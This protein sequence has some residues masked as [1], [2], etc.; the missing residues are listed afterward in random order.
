MREIRF[1]IWNKNGKRML[2]DSGLPI[3]G[4]KVIEE[5]GF[6]VMQFTGLQDK[7]GQKIYEGDIVYDETIKAK[8]EI[9]FGLFEGVSNEYGYYKCLGFHRKWSDNSGYSI[10][11]GENDLEIIGN[12]YKN[13]RLLHKP[14]K[15]Q[16]EN[17]TTK[18]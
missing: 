15:K 14:V 11:S 2:Y 3:K 18:K 7:N 8:S 1:R 4:N 5:I 10:L 12:I 17:K 13:P 16:G 9:V 6:K